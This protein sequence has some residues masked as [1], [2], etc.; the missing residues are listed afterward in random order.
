MSIPLLKATPTRESDGSSRVSGGQQRRAKPKAKRCGAKANADGPVDLG[1]PKN[2]LTG[3]WQR[4]HQQ[5]SQRQ[6]RRRERQIV[7]ALAR[8]GLGLTLAGTAMSWILPFQRG[9]LG[10]PRRDTS[11]SGPEHLRMAFEDLGPTFIKLAQILSTR[12]DL[13]G[14]DYASE[15]ARLQSSVPPLPFTDIAG[16]IESELGATFGELFAQIDDCSTSSA[17]P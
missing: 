2:P 10:H 5:W 8:H 3:R 7:S 9:L 11:Y 12:G 6:R 16:V 15:L 17:S 4:R 14:P 13:V 1:K